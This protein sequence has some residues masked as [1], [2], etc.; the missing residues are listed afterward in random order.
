[1]NVQDILICPLIAVIFGFELATAPFANGYPGTDSAAF[2]YI[3]RRMHE[4][5]IPYVDLFD[6]KGI[7][8]YLIEYFGLSISGG[9]FFGV[10]ILE[11]AGLFATAL[12]VM[13]IAA[14]FS[15]KKEAG[16]LSVVGTLFIFYGIYDNRRWKCCRRIR[17]SVDNC[18]I[19]YCT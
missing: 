13:K 6:H 12:L 16:Y 19:I 3:G 2:L 15:E 8:L 17:T 5:A 10:W 7:I 14:L 9:K 11:I 1:M 18:R 4:G